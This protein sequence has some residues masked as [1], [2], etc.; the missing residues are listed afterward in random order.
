[1][2]LPRCVYSRNSVKSSFD[3][4][5]GFCFCKFS[6]SFKCKKFDKKCANSTQR[7]QSP[8]SSGCQSKLYS[9][10]PGYLSPGNSIVLGIAA[11]LL[12]IS[13]RFFCR[14]WGNSSKLP[15]DLFIFVTLYHKSAPVSHF[16]CTY[17]NFL[18]SKITQHDI[19]VHKGWK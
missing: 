9:P 2:K 6:F 17:A 1:M 15:T 14:F 10:R 4:V 8:N 12:F 7:S 19:K 18:S 11:T 3:T 16:I 5:P 13:V